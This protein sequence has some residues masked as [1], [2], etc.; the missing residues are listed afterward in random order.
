VLD[1]PAADK[2]KIVPPSDASTSSH[3]SSPLSPVQSSIMAFKIS[4]WSSHSTPFF[5]II[6]SIPYS[7]AHSSSPTINLVVTVVDCDVVAEL[8]NE[9]VAVD[10]C[11]VVAELVNELVAVDDCD[12]VAELVNELVAVDD[13]DVVAELVAVELAVVV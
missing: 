4:F 2:V 8:V 11:D 13:C 9:L 6:N 3:V 12:V 10:D 5:T 1:P 7:V